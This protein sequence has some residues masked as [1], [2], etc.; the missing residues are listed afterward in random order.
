MF[1]GEAGFVEIVGSVEFVGSALLDGFVE[2]VEIL[3]F[4][5]MKGLLVLL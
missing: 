1:G 2:L 5:C 3:G 4:L